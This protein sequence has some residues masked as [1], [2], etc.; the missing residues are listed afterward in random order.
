M[1]VMLVNMDNKRCNDDGNVMPKVIGVDVADM[2]RPPY[3]APSMAAAIYVD[4]RSGG[5]DG[6]DFVVCGGTS[7][8]IEVRSRVS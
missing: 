3:V 4:P 6:L 2:T 8:Q 7:T 5:N 1:R